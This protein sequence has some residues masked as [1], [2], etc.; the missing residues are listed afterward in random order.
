MILVIIKLRQC[1]VAIATVSVSVS[2]SSV[3]LTVSTSRCRSNCHR[4]SPDRSVPPAGRRERSVG[5]A[6]VL[7]WDD[8]LFYS[9]V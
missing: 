4:S 5:D 8:L 6:W 7:Q 1:V 3:G 9:C 2:L